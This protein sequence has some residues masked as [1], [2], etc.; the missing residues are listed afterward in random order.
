MF[1]LKL[2]FKKKSFLIS[3][4]A[5][6]F[7]SILSFVL[8]CI[9][10]FGAELNS[11]PS[12]EKVFVW[13]NGQ[14]AIALVLLYLFPVFCVLPFADSYIAE[15][16]SNMLPV[17]LPR[18]GTKRYLFEKLLAVAASAFV[19]V[20]VP[21]ILNFI[22]SAVTFPTEINNYSSVSA[23]QSWFFSTRRISSL[24]FPRFYIKHP[25]LTNLSS[26]LLTGLFCAL[27]AAVVC[28]LSVFWN[29]SRVL[30]LSVFFI[31]NATLSLAS[32]IIATEKISC[33][34]PFYYTMLGNDEN[35]KN[36]LFFYAI[37]IVP[38]V[39]TMVLFPLCIKK[40]KKC[41]G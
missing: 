5:A 32:N 17:L 33:F 36:V 18:L 20:A 39:L 9:K 38:F 11:I 8:Y 22:L 29:R 34:V 27:S 15:K 12:A 6:S 37:F 1:R 21:L 40:I 14:D 25:Y 2:V 13:S 7:L 23:D 41:W 31:V 19:V 10:F 30:I 26:V 35:G 4:L 3:L 16:D 24:I 28:E